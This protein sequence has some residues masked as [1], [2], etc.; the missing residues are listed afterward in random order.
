MKI[1]HYSE[2]GVSFAK[3]TRLAL[4]AFLNHKKA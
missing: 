1:K 2:P 3:I 4:I